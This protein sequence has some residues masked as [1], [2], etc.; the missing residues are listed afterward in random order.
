MIASKHTWPYLI[1]YDNH[2]TTSLFQETSYIKWDVAKY[3]D[4]RNQILRIKYEATLSF[5]GRKVLNFF[6]L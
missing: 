5:Y 2:L 6:F 4:P 1:S 3:R